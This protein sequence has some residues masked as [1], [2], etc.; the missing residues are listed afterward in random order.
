[1]GKKYTETDQ[2]RLT[3]EAAK[4]VDHLYQ[5][6]TVNYIGSVK[7]GTTPYYEVSAKWLLENINILKS[8]S[9]MPRLPDSSYKREGHD[10]LND[11]GT[12]G[13]PEKLQAKALFNYSNDFGLQGI[14]FIDYEMPLNEY[15]GTGNGDV[16]LVGLSCDGKILYLMELKNVEN[17]ETLLRSAL[18]IYTYYAHLGFDK[19]EYRDEMIK[20]IRRDYKLKFE[21]VVPCILFFEGSK[22]HGY[23][24]NRDMSPNLMKLIQSLGIQVFMARRMEGTKAIPFINNE[25]CCGYK[26]GDKR[27]VLNITTDQKLVIEEQ[28]F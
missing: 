28:L 13:I 3:I 10:G 9:Y 7:G 23:F 12:R 17:D 20:R 15:E 6:K 25:D 21:S 11:R 14:R 18:E 27:P 2:L 5:D 8:I 19:D 26:L 16:D 1:M 22:Q 24:I 4:N